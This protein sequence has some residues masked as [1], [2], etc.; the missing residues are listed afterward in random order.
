MLVDLDDADR[1]GARPC[2]SA[3]CSTAARKDMTAS[4]P[5]TRTR[6]DGARGVRSRAARVSCSSSAAGRCGTSARSCARGRSADLRPADIEQNL[7]EL[8]GVLGD[9]VV[10]EAGG[11]VQARAQHRARAAGRCRRRPAICAAALTEPAE[12]GVARRDRAPRA[13]HRRA[14]AA[15]RDFKAAYA[16]AAAFE[17]AVARFFTEVFVMADDAK[18]RD[19]AAAADEAARGTHPAAGRIS[20]IVAPDA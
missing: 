11:G 20:E 15:G 19:G 17:P 8:R 9:G 16:E 18:L 4:R 7:R 5:P 3:R 12:V 13:G 10:P 2:R 14:A 6:L 1:L